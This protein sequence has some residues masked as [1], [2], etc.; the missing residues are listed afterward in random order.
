MRLC[1]DSRSRS[2]QPLVSARD[3][4]RARARVKAKTRARLVRSTRA[5]LPATTCDAII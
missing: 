1:D 2:R 3:R 5:E 4:I